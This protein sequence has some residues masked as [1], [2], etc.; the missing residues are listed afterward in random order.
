L[1]FFAETSYKGS[2]AEAE[3]RGGSLA[4]PAADRREGFMT[5]ARDTKKDEKKKPLKT[6][7]EKKMA[8]L[9]KKQK[10]ATDAI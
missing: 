6:H 7:K 8:K 9:E 5:K 2:I 10:K 4:M 1:S 3:A